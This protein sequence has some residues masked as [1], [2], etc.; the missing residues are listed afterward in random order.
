MRSSIALL[1]AS[2]LV[3]F[4]AP[5]MAAEAGEAMAASTAATANAAESDEKIVVE[6]QR[7][8]YGARNISSATKTNTPLRNVPQAVSVISASQIEDQQLRSIG[9][10]LYFVPGASVGTGEGNRDQIVLRGNSSTADFFIDGIRDDTQYIRDFYNVERMEVLKGPNAMIFGRGG[11]GG[12][13]N[14]VTKR[15]TL[16][17][18]RQLLT[19][20]DGFGGL[21][22]TGDF[23]QPLGDNVG[24]RINGLYEHGDS[25][26]HHVDLKRF[27]VNPT[28]GVMAGPDTR[29]DLGYEY[30]HDRRT[31]DRGVPSL[32]G[33]PLEGFDRTFFGDP[34]D[35]NVKADV[36]LA[37]LATEHQFADGLTLRNRTM[38]GDYDKFYQNIFGNGLSPA[39]PLNPSEIG[40]QV[41]MN[42]YNNDTE[43]QN[44]FSQTDLIWENRLAGIDQTMLFGFEVGIQKSRNRRETGSFAG[45]D[46]R[47]ELTG[48]TI[49]ANLTFAPIASDANNRT[50]AT[51]AA[52]YVQDQIRFSQMFEMVVGLRFDSFNLNVDDLRPQ[53]NREFSRRDNL[54]SPRIGL[55]FK[56]GDNLSLYASYSRSYLPQSGD[57]FSGLDV[58]T[59]SL[60]PERFDNYELGAKWEP[61]QGLL[62]T[63]AVYQLDR[64]NT[65][66]ANPDSSGTF[67]LSG[68][69]RTRGVELGLERNINDDWQIS[70]GYA[71]QKA[72]VTKA[73]TAC[74][75]GDCKLPLVP[76][77]SLSLWT[78]YDVLDSLGFGLGVIARSKSYASIGNRVELPGYARV[79]GAIYYKLLDG[80]EAQL[81]VENILN[82]DYFPSANGDNNIAPGA[83]RSIKG[84][85]RFGL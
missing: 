47:F 7:E 72:E 64:A 77:H 76:R 73:T 58:N 75:S 1:T 22:F 15:S 56:P 46:N 45:G 66:V 17:S 60:K 20:G 29:I 82:V 24:L 41:V 70:A 40:T 51:V 68:E 52:A 61:V 4:A 67:L 49:D 55:I 3:A 48:P 43:R 11:G 74:P 62:A 33:K 50:R 36:H 34:D 27:A 26:R 16:H 2:S 9:E 83:P 57:Q 28:L 14:R 85:V 78:R 12:I 10:A 35:S 21:R 13:I 84:T 38:A 53:V 6:G 42:A 39:N 54:W 69:Q 23:D 37:T 18:N 71:W 19:S 81:N 5:A 79:D 30:L 25:F 31:A 44:L 32:S 63:A 59:E 65:R 80:I 8:T